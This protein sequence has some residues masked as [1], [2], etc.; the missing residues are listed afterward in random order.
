MKAAIFHVVVKEILRGFPQTVR[1]AL[2]KAIWE[3]QQ[4]IHLGM[5]ISKRMP[6]VAAG[7]EELRVKDASGAYRAF[8][9]SRSNRGILI[10]HA[11]EKKARKTPE[12]EIK[13]GR[14]RLKEMLDEAA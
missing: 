13:L 7:V 4:G 5:P 8:Y 10:F 6:S 9:Y 12:S 1:Q 14:K 3:L 11:F 2:G